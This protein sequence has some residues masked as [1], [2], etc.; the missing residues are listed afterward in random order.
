MKALV[1]VASFGLDQCVSTLDSVDA[2]PSAGLNA[3]LM[4][5]AHPGL[6]TGRVRAA[7]GRSLA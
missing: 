2:L 6:S 4:P 5:R 3:A 7:F 1:Y